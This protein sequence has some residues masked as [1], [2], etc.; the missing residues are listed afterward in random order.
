MPE[1][2]TPK[3]K[4]YNVRLDVDI[5]AKLTGFDSAKSPGRAHHG[6]MKNFSSPLLLGPP[7]SDELL[8]LMTHVFTEDE[9]DAA[10]H[11]LPL[12]PLTAKQVALL[13]GRPAGDV[14]ATLD[15]LSENKRVILYFG[16]PR[17]YTILPLV[18]G[19]FEMIVI[20]HDLSRNSRWH[21]KFA[22]HLEKIWDTGYMKDYAAVAAP[23]TVRFLPTQS[24]TSRL[25]AAWPSDMLEELLDPYDLF[26]IAHCQCRVLTHLAGR[27]CG[28]P[29]DNCVGI[30]P[31]AQPLIDRGFLRRT[32]KREVIEAKKIAEENG[33]VTF[34]M[35][36]LSS[37]EGNYSCS[38]C[39]CCCHVMHTIFQFNMPG[40]VSAP[41]FMPRRR[42]EACTHCGLCSAA[43]PAGAWKKIGDAICFESQRCIGCGLCVTSC[44]K[45]VLELKPVP[46][47]KKPEKAYRTQ[48]LESLP[49]YA[50][51]SFRIWLR[52]T[53]GI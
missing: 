18:P 52:R 10:Q 26:G 40:L 23:F 43:C 45:N 27:G 11:L 44:G 21:K 49:S 6:L 34:M 28:K 50:A 51:N 36:G 14:E 35:S 30:G 24:N 8:E 32:D 20:S 33:C 31:L 19:T 46:K 53:A 37:K 7:P 1:T 5:N 47:A 22:D 25:Q 17:R 16:E 4:T 41:Y 15:N 12:I 3:K 13:C 9:A 48:L 42:D 38:C 29:T 39:G 2:K